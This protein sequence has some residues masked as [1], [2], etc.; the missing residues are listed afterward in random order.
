MNLRILVLFL[1]FALTAC[2]QLPTHDGAAKNEKSLGA[3]QEKKYPGLTRKRTRL[4]PN[5][6]LMNPNCPNRN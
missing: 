1:L 3:T 6:K 4:V 2:A 5:M